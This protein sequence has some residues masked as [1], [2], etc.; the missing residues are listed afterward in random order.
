MAYPG[1]VA[2]NEIYSVRVDE[3]ALEVK[4]GTSANPDLVGRMDYGT[5][6][7]LGSG[8]LTVADALRGGRAT[9]EG[10]I[11]TAER[12]AEILRPRFR[13]PEADKG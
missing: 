13:D 2:P 1:A 11:A 7:A 8:Q 6:F 3:G 4:Q 9:I 10:D 12:C 5:L